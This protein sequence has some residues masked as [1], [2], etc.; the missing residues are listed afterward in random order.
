M[1]ILIIFC[2]CIYEISMSGYVRYISGADV[3]DACN[4]LTA[5]SIGSLPGRQGEGLPTV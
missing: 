4:L 3:R 2:M 5:V 1:H